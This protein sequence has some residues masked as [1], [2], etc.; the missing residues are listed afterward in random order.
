MSR[1]NGVREKIRR[2]RSSVYGCQIHID[3]IKHWVGQWPSEEQAAR[4]YDYFVI[5]EYGHR[6]FKKLNFPTDRHRAADLA[7]PGIR[8][9]TKSIEKE[10]R[11]AE[12]Q[13][14]RRNARPRTTPW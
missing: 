6:A 10:H 2:D 5:E 9:F 4:A 8:H 1:Y 11:M 13:I 3:G 12:E 14:A 7:P